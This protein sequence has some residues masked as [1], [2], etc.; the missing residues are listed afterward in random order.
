MMINVLFVMTDSFSVQTDVEIVGQ[1]VKHA[2]T[3]KLTDVPL[4]KLDS[5]LLDRIVIIVLLVV[6]I[7]TQVRHAPHA[8]LIT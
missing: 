8:C 5:F 7:V 2:Q 6:L 1:D 3:L 4:A